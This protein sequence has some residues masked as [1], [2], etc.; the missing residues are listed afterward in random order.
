MKSFHKIF[1]VLVSAVLFLVIAI[2]LKAETSIADHH[3]HD[4]HAASGLSLDQGKKWKTDAPLRK[5]MQSI[6]DAVM[7]AVPSFHHHTLKKPDAE[8]LARHINDQV[9]Y[10]VANCKLE[11]KA[12]AT[13][14]VF[15][16]E[17]LSAADT[18]SKEPL[19]N[20]GLPAIVNVLHQYPVYFDHQGWN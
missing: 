19:S 6:N 8:K 4:G 20:Q 10:L 13:L 12:D 2:P 11:P 5:G 14:H 15:I 16:G 9:A 7:N 17:L 1:I 18:L 3:S